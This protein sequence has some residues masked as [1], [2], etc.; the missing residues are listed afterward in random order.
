MLRKLALFAAV[1]CATAALGQ[2]PQPAS[3][4]AQPG[5]TQASAPQAPTAAPSSNTKQPALPRHDEQLVV[6]G[7]YAAVPMEETDRSVSTIPVEQS[8]VV[9]RNWA[10]ALE[11]EPSLDVQQR[12]PGTSADLSI[13][14]AT[15][16][17][18]L[19][20]VN[21]LRLND[22]QTGHNNLD[23]PFPFAAVERIE[24][25]KGA[26]ST[27]YGSDAMGGAVNFITAVPTRSEFR[28]GAAMGNFGTNLENGVASWVRPHFSQQLTF[29]RELSSGF[30]VDRNYRN[31]AFGA[32]TVFTTAAGRSDVLLGLSDRP[33][34]AAGFYGCLLYTSASTWCH[35]LCLLC[36][37]ARKTFRCLPATS[38]VSSARS[39]DAA[40][41]RSPTRHSTCSP[42]TVGLATCASCAT[43]SSASSS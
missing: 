4:A 35:S 42:V 14:G 12:A 32:E 24:V 39:T 18:S 22:V 23:L 7:S 37:S 31:L 29:V 34:G 27:L 30:T 43:S 17:E 9:F 41:E 11:Q 10:D 2:T 21:G 8:P 1:L 5:S 40:P 25:L 36:A 33:Y 38:C 20:L 26:G 16:G 15:F 28:L 19:I 3:P 13:R 6:T